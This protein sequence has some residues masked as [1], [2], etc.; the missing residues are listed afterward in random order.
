LNTLKLVAPNPYGLH[1]TTKLKPT[2]TFESLSN[3]III[4]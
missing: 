2:Q 3:C 4:V 1:R